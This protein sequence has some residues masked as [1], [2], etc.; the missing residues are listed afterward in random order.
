MVILTFIGIDDQYR[1]ILIRSC[2]S[3]VIYFPI[4]RV[5]GL[6]KKDEIQKR[7]KTEGEREKERGKEGERKI[8]CALD[9]YQRCTF[10]L[11]KEKMQKKVCSLPGPQLNKSAAL[12][13]LRSG[14][15]NTG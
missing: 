9:I 12:I 2:P 1:A 4:K 3:T 8:H 10:T 7:R 14:H 13:S 5:K 11:T 15:S 6:T